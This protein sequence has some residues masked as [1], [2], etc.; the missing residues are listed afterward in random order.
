MSSTVLHFPVLYFQRPRTSSVTRRAYTSLLSRGCMHP[1]LTA[2]LYIPAGTK[3]RPVFRMAQPVELSK[4]RSCK[5]RRASS[6]PAACADSLSGTNSACDSRSVFYAYRLYY[7]WISV[8]C[9][10]YGAKNGRNIAISTKFSHFGGCYA[11]PPLSIRTK[12]GEKH[13]RSTIRLHAKLHLNPLRPIVSLSREEKPQF[14]ANFDI[15][16]LLYPAPFT[17][18]G[19]IWYARADPWSTLIC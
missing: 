3:R 11:H 6:K 17:D 19:Q 14:W 5:H 9:R 15:W 13:R 10:P 7:I 18:Y 1:W 16:G 4:T 2:N 8:L 12:F